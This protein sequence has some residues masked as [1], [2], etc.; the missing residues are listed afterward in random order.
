M[1]IYHSK[2]ILYY[3]I[4]KKNPFVYFWVSSEEDKKNL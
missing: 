1:Y 3:E 4:K 2:S